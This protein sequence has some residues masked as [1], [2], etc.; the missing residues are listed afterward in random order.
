MLLNFAAD[1]D[2]NGPESIAQVLYDVGLD[3]HG[4]LEAAQ[5]EPNK[6]ALRA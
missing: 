2:I 6:L 4:I 1:K 5:A 3:A